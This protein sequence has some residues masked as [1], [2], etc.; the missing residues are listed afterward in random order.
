MGIK[1]KLLLMGTLMALLV[2]TI[3]GIGYYKAQT[4]ETIAASLRR[5]VGRHAQALNELR[6]EEKARLRERMGHTP[7]EIAGGI[8]VGCAVA[9]LLR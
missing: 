7:F 5:Q 6:P 1:Q 9:W 3:C 4:G 8:A 2:V